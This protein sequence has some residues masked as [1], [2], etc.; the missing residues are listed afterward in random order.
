MKW[1]FR[2]REYPEN[3]ISSETNKVKFSNLSLQSN[4]K[5]HNKKGIPLVV[6]YHP[7]L[8]SLSA[9]IDKKLSILYMNKEVKKVFNPRPIVSFRSASKSNSYLVRTKLYPL[10]R[11]VGSYKFK[12]K[13]CQVCN[14][15]TEADSF[16]YSNGQLN[17][18]I[19]HKFDCN[20]KSLIYLIT[21]S[22]CLKE[23]V[24]QTVDEF[25][26]RWNNH[27]DNARKFERGEHCMQRHL[28]EHFNVPGHSGFLND[29]SVTL[30]D[31]TDPKGP[32]K[33]EDY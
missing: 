14:N 29:V 18:K 3:L 28:Y 31:K 12:G 30:I 4:D 22:R 10:D 24:G 32:T 20:E 15:I 9:I 26:H 27:K 23:C 21:C 8:K 5:N 25:R 16:N 19:N 2:K 1:W 11:T 6:T 7:L 13:R 33:R 17:F